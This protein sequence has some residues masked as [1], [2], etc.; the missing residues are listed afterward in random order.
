MLVGASGAHAWWYA[1]SP[2]T[3][4]RSCGKTIFPQP[5]QGEGPVGL[6]V[7]AAALI[8]PPAPPHVRRAAT[9]G[10]RRIPSDV[11]GHDWRQP[12]GLHRDLRMGSMR[13]PGSSRLGI[14]PRGSA[15]PGDARS[16]RT[17]S[18]CAS[19]T[20]LHVIR[21]DAHRSGDVEPVAIDTGLS[22]QEGEEDSTEDLDEPKRLSYLWD[23]RQVTP[24]LAQSIGT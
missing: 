4:G 7:I 15:R 5:P 23:A 10:V 9:P 24:N 12:R 6:Q 14:W 19:S 20:G 13:L 16:P 3:I 17:G 1:T 18:R 2:S 22:F 8:G 21:I 11:R